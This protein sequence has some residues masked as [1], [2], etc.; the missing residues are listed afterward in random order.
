MMNL[1]INFYYWD[2]LIVIK[3]YLKLCLIFIKMSG[4]IIFN[5]DKLDTFYPRLGTRHR[6]LLL[7][8]LLN[9]VLDPVASTVR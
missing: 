2:F 4:S 1:G 6:N 7:P 5:G 9:I 3:W 8:L